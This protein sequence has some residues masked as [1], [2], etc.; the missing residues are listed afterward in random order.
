MQHG[1]RKKRTTTAIHPFWFKL[2]EHSP[3]ATPNRAKSTAPRRRAPEFRLNPI[4]VLARARVCR[5]S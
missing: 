5:A 3:L 1:K 4:K 2:N